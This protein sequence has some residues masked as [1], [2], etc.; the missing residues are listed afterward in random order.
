MLSALARLEASIGLID[1][2]DTTTATNES[3]VAMATLERLKRIADFHS[4]T[5]LSGCGGVS[6]TFEKV[7]KI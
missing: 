5:P 2:I 4:Y 7:N 3:V 1:N 6:D